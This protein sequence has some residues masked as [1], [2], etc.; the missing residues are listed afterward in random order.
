MG[1]GWCGLL[2]GCVTEHAAATSLCLSFVTYETGTI[3]VLLPRLNL[4][5]SE[6]IPL[7]S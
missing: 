2:T 1:L 6:I 4:R 3:L 5:L 7:S